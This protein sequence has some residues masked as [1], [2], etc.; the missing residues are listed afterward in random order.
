MARKRKIVEMWPD[1]IKNEREVQ[2]L[3]ELENFHKDALQNQVHLN[4]LGVP[5]NFPFS[6][7]ISQLE[8]MTKELV[9]EGK[10]RKQCPYYASR[11]LAAKAEVVFAP[12][13]YIVDPLIRSTCDIDLTNNVLVFDEAHNMEGICADSGSVE[14]PLDRIE[15]AK[16]N[17][18]AVINNFPEIN[19]AKFAEILEHLSDWIHDQAKSPFPEK[20][21]TRVSK[22]WNGFEAIALIQGIGIN[23]DNLNNLLADLKRLNDSLFRDDDQVE[24][25]V[26][27]SHAKE[28][29]KNI[30][31][32]VLTANLLTELLT[33][34]EYLIFPGHSFETDYKMILSRQSGERDGVSSFDYVLGFRCLNPGV[35]F[36]DIAAKCRSVILTS[37]TL[38][39][40]DTYESELRVKFHDSL[41]APH[42]IEKNQI[43]VGLV[44]K[45]L[46]GKPFIGDYQTYKTNDYQDQL[47]LTIYR[48]TKHIPN[49]ILIFVPAYSWI[50]TLEHRWRETGLW[51]TFEKTFTLFKEPRKG[52]KAALQELLE[53]Y[54]T[55]CKSGQTI[56]LCVFRGKM[57]EGIDFANERARGVLCI[58]LPFPSIGDL[59]VKQKRIYN[60]AFSLKKNLLTGSEWF[61]IQA[62]RAINQ[63]LGR[64]IR[65]KNDWGCV[66]LIDARFAAAKNI[67]LLPKWIQPFLK[68][69]DTAKAVEKDLKLFLQNIQ[70][71]DGKRP[72]S[73]TPVMASEV[74]SDVRTPA[75]SEL[76]EST[77]QVDITPVKPKPST[78]FITPI[79]KIQTAALGTR[80]LSSYFTPLKSELNHTAIFEP[81]VEK[82]TV[83]EEAYEQKEY[84]CYECG[85][86]I[87][88]TVEEHTWEYQFLSVLGFTSSYCTT[89]NNITGMKLY[90][91][92][93]DTDSRKIGE[94][95]HKFF[96]CTGCDSLTGVL[97]DDFVIFVD[98]V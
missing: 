29:T 31:I 47:G 75:N 64:C 39:P 86:A 43:C 56:L 59:K 51:T 38:S 63:A 46:D 77:G 80:S 69:Y 71:F 10:K 87:A 89:L 1:L 15:L 94:L 67:H 57:S 16:S 53:K 93:Y 48:V 7:Y 35:I 22:I 28:Q 19:V 3:K 88:S 37:G 92:K 74:R 70:D 21:F 2:R 9:Q 11:L 52:K 82:E 58:G 65:H 32:S 27:S 33:I 85:N 14:I 68:I 44:S 50:E 73:T 4:I 24:V 30:K 41:E 45:G 83:P 62:F 12:Y 84:Y 8:I 34:V 25:D 40:M 55:S 72:F 18:K 5:V 61:E 90:R 49:G 95:Y 6:P 54:N 26:Q 13:N 96:E 17:L 60:D 79:S 81:A 98:K 23:S 36:Q 91:G 76:I 78:N 20:E 97:V 66:L 42:V